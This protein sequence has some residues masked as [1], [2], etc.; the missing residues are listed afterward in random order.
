M[1]TI[2]SGVPFKTD[3]ALKFAFPTETTAKV[4]IFASN[5]KF[6]TLEASKLPGGRGHGEPVRLYFE[7]RTGRRR[8]GGMAYQG[9]RKFLVASY[10]GN[11]FVVAGG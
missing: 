4:L 11:G 7:H 10:G 1:S 5:G 2:S 3:D 9:G 8:G 6:Y